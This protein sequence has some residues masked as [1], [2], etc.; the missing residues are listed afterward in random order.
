MA[1]IKTS[2]ISANNTASNVYGYWSGLVTNKPTVLNSQMNSFGAYNRGDVLTNDLNEIG[3]TGIPDVS[4]PIY[5]GNIGGQYVYS[6]GSAP[7]GASDII[8]IGYT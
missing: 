6:L 5:R 3:I 7:V 2:A 1:S 8:I 4:Q